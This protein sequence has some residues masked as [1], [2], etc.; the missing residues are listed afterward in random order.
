[1]LKNAQPGKSA[2][3]QSGGLPAQKKEQPNT[4]LKVFGPVAS[5]VLALFLILSFLFRWLNVDKAWAGFGQGGS[6]SILNLLT[7]GAQI[8]GAASG[9]AVPALTTV[10]VLLAAVSAVLLLVHAAMSLAGR[11]LKWFS[12][13]AFGTAAFFVAFFMVATPVINSI[14]GLNTLT[15]SVFPVLGMLAALLGLFF[16]AVDF[17]DFATDI[18][19]N[20][21][22]LYMLA[23]G[24]IY[25]LI[26]SYLP[27]PGIAMAFQK[28]PVGGSFI[29]NFLSAQFVGLHNFEFFF[30][31]PDAPIVLRNT[32]LYNVTFIILGLMASVFVAV[33]A[34]E[35]YS[36]VA[37][38]FYQ[39]VMVLPAFLSWVVVSYL[40]YSILQPDFGSANSLLKSIG[41]D[42]V[43]WY[44]NNSLWPFI[45]PFL[46]LWKGVGL[47][48]IYYFAAISG[49]DQ[50]MY[51]ASWLDGASRFKQ[52]IH[53]TLPCLR[54]T[55]IIMTI[56]SMGSMIRTDFGLFYIATNQMGH[57]ALYNVAS[58]ID[59]FVYSTVSTGKY[60]LGAASGLFQSVVGLV[61]ILGV[62]AI[63]RKVD[64]DSS[65][66]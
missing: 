8:Q 43:S 63:V 13:V 39:S 51:E 30:K 35:I 14:I 59:T 48:S 32:I 60:T 24:V 11:A 49:I 57:G 20:R 31:S 41:V 58:T 61:M 26:F 36:K 47:G 7:Y 45:L 54:T 33:A 12:V 28:L 5:V 44:N 62:N 55:M 29:K 64:P 9:T 22:F 19:K 3:V 46:N 4:L 21:M 34:S 17:A 2:K 53:I 1:M 66:F 42:P 38:K 56:L 27:M 65:M 6:L 25:L 15:V 50:E 40:V 16:A 10:I 52:I 18:R 23:P 37:T